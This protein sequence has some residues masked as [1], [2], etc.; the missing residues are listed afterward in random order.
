MPR[1]KRIAIL[2][3]CAVLVVL[4]SIITIVLLYTKTDVFKSSREL[5]VKY[6]MKNIDNID[7]I[8]NNLENDILDGKKYTSS[9]NIKLNYVKDAGTSSEN[10]KNSINQYSLSLEGK[11]DKQANYN[12]Q[13]IKVLDA[14]DKEKMKFEFIKDNNT[15]GIKFSDLF[16]QYILVDN[17]NLKDIYNDINS[18]SNQDVDFPDSIQDL[19]KLNEV[20]KFSDEEKRI[21]KDKY[22]KIFEKEFQIGQVEKETNQII[23]INEQELKTT[24][25]ILTLSK[26]QINNI[27]LKLLEEIKEDDIILKKLENVNEI[28]SSYNLLL[29]L[30]EEINLKENFINKIN[31]TIEKINKN[32][33]GQEETKIIVYVNNNS[34][35]RTKIKYLEYEINIDFFE[36]NYVQ[37]KVGKIDT[38]ETKTYTLSL[39]NNSME[40]DF[41]ENIDGTVKDFNI[42]KVT[43]VNEEKV[44]NNVTI[45]YEAGTSKIET[46]IDQNITI[47]NE[48]K[49]LPKINNDNAIK[50]NNLDKETNQELVNRVKSALTKKIDST[51]VNNE[52]EDFNTILKAIGLKND[53]QEI[54]LIGVTEA[55]RNRYNSQF[56]ILQGENLKSEDIIKSINAIESNISK[57][58][59]VSNTELKLKLVKS[60]STDNED[61][62]EQLTEFL[63]KNSNKNYNIKIEYDKNGLAN[64]IILNI[65]TE[66]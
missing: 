7:N 21:L 3:T 30:K 17:Y 35:V 28:L 37:F 63:K 29:N 40:L 19:E 36:N 47:E 23:T 39:K 14:K 27:Y 45:K 1:K 25:F 59:V 43:Q 4:I 61:V 66:E 18:N 46:T 58:D 8:N 55:A 20:I 42:S 50:L 16:Y 49:D 57:I 5:L 15:Y 13:E 48:L 41:N 24:A 2:C 26:E 32:N 56:D 9:T 22:K 31:K 44:K 6:M 62:I 10:T 64:Y 65:V 34:T 54:E 33:I 51:F 12:F 60:K 52:K 11:V 53:I 38:V